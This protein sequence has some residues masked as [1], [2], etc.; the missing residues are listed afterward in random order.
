[1]AA[2]PRREDRVLGARALQL[3]AHEARRELVAGPTLYRPAPR[4]GRRRV[5]VAAAQHVRRERP[6]RRHARI[7]G[8]RAVDRA[9][10][11][12]RAA[13]AEIV[14]ARARQ[15][16]GEDAARARAPLAR[17]RAHLRSVLAGADVAPPRRA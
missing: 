16:V 1:V 3:V 17:R 15:L 5:E 8:A 11:L 9:D 12:V 7:A 6:A 10:A 13:V 14:A 2:E 4:G